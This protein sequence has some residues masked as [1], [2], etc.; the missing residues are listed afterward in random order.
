MS[1]LLIIQNITRE[2]PGLLA[3][4]LQEE[5]I[6]FDIV[7]LDA[8]D[9][10]PPIIDYDALVVLGGP[11]SANDQTTKMINELDYINEALKTGIP[12]LGI[13][14]GLQTLVK[15]S[16][17]KVVK[18]EVKEVGFIDP[19]GN[20][21]A[22]DVTEEGKADPLMAGLPDKLD[23]FQ[24][25]G[26]TVKLTSEMKLLAI[27]KFCTNQIVKV[28]DKA[29]G[30]QSHFEL[31]PEMLKVWANQDPDLIPVGVEKLLADFSA[32]QKSYTNIGKTL[33]RN[34]LD[35]AGLSQ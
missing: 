18:G 10:L 8:G 27:G 24:L 29:Y 32:I 2:G 31:T 15:A 21:N 19:E 33:L 30:I 1:E 23:V 35:I 20:Q 26:E 13:C 22:V 34:F 4:V 25:H 28:A 12:Y 14:L 3:G 9:Q 16:G 17:G 7:D 11:D 6:S 5:N